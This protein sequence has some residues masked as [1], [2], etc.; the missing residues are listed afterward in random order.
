[1]VFTLACA[2]V[3]LGTLY[4][5]ALDAFYGDKITVGAPY[6]NTVMVP[7]FLLARVADGVGPLVPWR[8]ANVERLRK[9]LLIPLTVGAV[10]ATLMAT[11]MRPLHWTGPVAL[12]LVL[13]AFAALVTDYVR[14]VRIRRLQTQE[15]LGRSLVKTV[16]MNRR[17]YGGMVRALRDRR[18]CTRAHRV[19]LFRTRRLL[20]W[21]RRCDGDRR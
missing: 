20:R 17:H 15:G 5:L 9:R 18:H 19:G 6:F 13:F 4:P 21:R 7:I 10:A 11:F 12:G 1:V 2:C 8:K 16:L 3:L 14:A